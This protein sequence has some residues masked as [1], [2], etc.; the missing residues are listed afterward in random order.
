MTAREA[1][2][3]SGAARDAD[4]LL[5]I[6]RG[7]LARVIAASHRALRV[8]LPDQSTGYLDPQ[9]LSSVARPLL[10]TRLDSG[11]VLREFPGELAPAVELLTGAVMGDVLG[12]FGEF[13]LV[14][15]PEAGTGWVLAH[16]IG[17][18]PSCCQR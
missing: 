11:T 13:A 8:L 15:V 4:T 6:G 17:L 16:M 9:A 7:G 2:L 10:R 3:R 12:R 1:V 18:P 14:R 5:Q